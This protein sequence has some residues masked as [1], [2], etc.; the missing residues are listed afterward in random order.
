MEM[1]TWLSRGST[2]KYHVPNSDELMC[3][4]CEKISHGTHKKISHGKHKITSYG[5]HVWV[6]IKVSCARHMT[7]SC[8]YHIK[9]SHEKD[10]KFSLGYHMT[11]SH[12]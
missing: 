5:M 3:L 8:V 9:I 7:D 12:G 2:S 6:C 1:F 11:Y 4:P 10:I